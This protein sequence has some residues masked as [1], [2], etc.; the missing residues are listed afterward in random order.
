ME[1]FIIAAVLVFVT[2]FGVGYTIGAYTTDRIHRVWRE[3][4]PLGK[5]A[6]HVTN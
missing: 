1:Y 2:G 3:Q 6:E 4:A 5:E